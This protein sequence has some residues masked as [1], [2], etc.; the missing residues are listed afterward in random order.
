MASLV[1][2]TRE[3]VPVPVSK[4]YAT[5]PCPYSPLFQPPQSPTGVLSMDSQKET[6]R[7]SND[8][9]PR[10]LFSME[11][12]LQNNKGPDAQVPAA[13]ESTATDSEPEPAPATALA[14]APAAGSQLSIHKDPILQGGTLSTANLEELR[15]IFTFPE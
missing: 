14:L 11:S 6:V 12:C 8:F 15:S 2:A 1:S 3:V 7:S 4:P 5:L 10:M 9:I 13:V